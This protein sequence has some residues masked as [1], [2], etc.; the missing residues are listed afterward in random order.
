MSLR[1]EGRSVTLEAVLREP[2]P[3]GATRGAAVVCHP[4]PLYGGTMDNRVVFRVGKAIVDSGLAALRFNFRGIGASTGSYDQGTGE[5]A[6]VSAAL[7]W[8]QRKYHDLPLVV[9]GFS[10]G[11][12]VGLQVGAADPRVTALVGLGLPLSAYSFDFLVENAKPSLYVVGTRDEYCPGPD[13]ERLAR[14]L[15]PSSKVH[16]IEG[17]DHF[18]IERL[19]EM[20]RVIAEFLC[21]VDK[22]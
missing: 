5:K 19:D 7:D 20:Q 18:F 1:I 22:A 6:D 3:E 8:L 12:W 11:A 14:R 21:S 4:H 10:F 17:A 2:H 13:L 9:A 15:P 16:R